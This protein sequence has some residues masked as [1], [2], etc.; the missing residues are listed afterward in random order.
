MTFKIV[1]ILITIILFSLSSKGQ[2]IDSTVLIEVMEFN[3]VA[4]KFDTVRSSETGQLIAIHY[5]DVEG[6]VKKVIYFKNGLVSGVINFLNDE[7][8]GPFVIYYE[9][10]AIE[11]Y[12]KYFHNKGFVFEFSREGKIIDFYQRDKNINQY[13]GYRAVYCS[14]GFL[15][16]ETYYNKS[17]YV[18]KR[19]Y[20]N[21][22]LNYVGN[23]VNFK[24]EGEW[25]FYDLNGKL[26][27]VELYEN[28]KL[29][30]IK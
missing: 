1:N 28:D 23:I 24:K 25:I 10:G 22:V 13:I 17:D 30:K 16:Q 27:K 11:S 5:A 14:N 21:G 8:H 6:I 12:G 18:Q 19:F 26:E 20:C 3:F 4:S 9:N 2:I 29:I 15:R 7:F